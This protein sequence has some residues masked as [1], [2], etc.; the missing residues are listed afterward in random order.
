MTIIIGLKTIFESFFLF[1]VIVVFKYNKDNHNV[2]KV[3]QTSFKDCIIPSSGG[4]TSGHDVITLA[5]P[6]KKWYICGFP[7]HCSDHNQKLVIT[8]EGEAP[9]PA[10][11]IPAPATPVPTPGPATKDD[12]NSS[13]RV[14][15]SAYKIFVGGVI[16]IWTILTLV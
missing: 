14:T 15:I 1:F 9:A 11:P 10:T 5:T 16:L 13:Y 8:V 7:S 12:S 4:L 6:G 3:N 2:F